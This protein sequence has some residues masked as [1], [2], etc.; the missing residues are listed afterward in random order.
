MMNRATLIGHVGADSESGATQS[1]TK[2]ARFRVATSERWKDKATGEKKQV[3]EWHSIVVWNEKLVPVVEQYVKKGTQVCVEGKITTRK[4]Q[5]KQGQD[6]YTTEIVLSDLVL[7]GSGNGADRNHA[8]IDDSAMPERQ[9]DRMS[10][11]SE[12]SSPGGAPGGGKPA[13]AGGGFSKNFEDE[14]PFGPEVR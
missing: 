2:L 6:R 10:N 13:P 5:D 12:A 4:W 7:L 1:G 9:R 14:I 11:S 8:P 3:T